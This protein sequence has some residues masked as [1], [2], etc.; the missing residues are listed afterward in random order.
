M[1]DA[2]TMGDVLGIGEDVAGDGGVQAPR[3]VTYKKNP[4]ATYE[5][6]FPSFLYGPASIVN[7]QPVAT[8]AVTK[9]A[10]NAKLVQ[11]LGTYVNQ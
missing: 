2:E 8:P 7:P 4:D 9:V 3:K 11:L 5:K 6:L 1:L 10:P